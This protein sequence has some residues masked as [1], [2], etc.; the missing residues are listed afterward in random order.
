METNVKNAKNVKN[1]AKEEKE[2]VRFTG[3]IEIDPKGGK[4]LCR[5]SEIEALK[6]QLKALQEAEKAEKAIN[7]TALITKAFANNPG[8]TL[9]QAKEVCAEAGINIEE[10]AKTIMS[11][12][13]CAKYVFNHLKAA[14]KIVE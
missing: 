3:A 2:N 10:K 5:K 4:V 6:A 11:A 9:E 7:A 1:V 13:N 12:L 14:G 8:L